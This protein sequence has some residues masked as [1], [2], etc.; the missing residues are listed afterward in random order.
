[1]ITKIGEKDAFGYD[2]AGHPVAAQLTQGEVAFGY[3]ICGRLQKAL[4]VGFQVTTQLYKDGNAL[5]VLFSPHAHGAELWV[6]KWKQDKPSKPRFIFNLSYT[7]LFERQFGSIEDVQSVLS[8][9]EPVALRPGYLTVEGPELEGLTPPASI[10]ADMLLDHLL[11]Q[12]TNPFVNERID[13]DFS[14][15]RRKRFRNGH[16]SFC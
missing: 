9:K 10:A 11:R 6:G 1:M 15:S 16:K 3:D 8:S 12:S 5:I 13:Y 2:D 4:A 7:G 14:A